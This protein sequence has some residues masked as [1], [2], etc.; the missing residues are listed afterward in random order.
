MKVIALCTN[1]EALENGGI[2]S[3]KTCKKYPGA[4][5]VPRFTEMAEKAGYYVMTG[6][7]ALANLKVF[8]NVYVIQEEINQLGQKLIDLGAKPTLSFCLESPIYAPLFYDRIPEIKNIFPYQI[9]FEG[10]THHTYFPSFDPEDV[11]PLV[12]WEKRKPLVMIASNKHYSGMES[13]YSGSKAF[14]WAIDHQLQD[15]RYQAIQHFRNLGVLDLYG[16]GWG[17]FAKPVEDK[18]ETMRDYKFAICFENGS[19]PGYITEK[20]IDCFVA[21]VIPIHAGAPDILD[22]VR[23]AFLD[24]NDFG[25]SWAALWDYAE[26]LG[27]YR[28]TS[29]LNS[30]RGFLLSPDGLKYSNDHFAKEVFSIVR[31]VSS[32]Q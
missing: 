1:L 19:Y 2:R 27:E 8:S 4:S 9:L 10:G 5:W 17:A 11:K 21:G 16:H 3:P 30:A 25:G 20:I 7:E 29:M 24:L 28:A 23:G 18:L 31:S 14:Q 6:N 12:P 26:K 13:Y 32:T 15:K 22:Y